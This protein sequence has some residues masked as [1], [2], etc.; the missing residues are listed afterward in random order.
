VHNDINPILLEMVPSVDADPHCLLSLKCYHAILKIL[1][2]REP[3]M[4]TC[5]EEAVIKLSR[6]VLRR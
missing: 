2:D 4:K 3:D 1:R 6:T 5:V